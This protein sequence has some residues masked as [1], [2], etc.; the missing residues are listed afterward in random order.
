MA[1]AVWWVALTMLAGVPDAGAA[2]RPLYYD[3][4][5]TDADLANRSPNELALMR[6]TV[7]ARAGREFKTPKL[8][9]YFA[10]QPWYHPS[11]GPVQLGAIDAANVRAILAR[12]RGPSAA[13]LRPAVFPCAE[14]RSNGTLVNKRNEAVLVKLAGT[15]HWEDDYGVPGDC[16]RHIALQCG[17]DLDGDGQP[18]SIASLSWLTPLNDESCTPGH[19]PMNNWENAKIFLLTGHAGHWR[20]LVPLGITINGDQQNQS[21]EADFV[22]RPD[23]T[24]AIHVHELEF[25]GGNGCS[26]DVDVVSGY[27]HG[28][29]R[30]ID[31]IDHSPP[32]DGQ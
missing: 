3:R 12:E 30:R 27:D 29:L 9:E 15:L 22:R 11:H 23:G 1:F 28:A 6:N 24:T 19:P 8:R 2:P 31:F 4:S 13:P 7:Y 18:E 21:R 20:A 17:P 32:C 5:I 16:E 26:S 14:A 25:D 10:R